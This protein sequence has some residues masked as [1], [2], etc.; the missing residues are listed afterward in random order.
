MNKFLLRI[1]VPLLLLVGLASPTY[2]QSGGPQASGDPPEPQVVMPVLNYHLSMPVVSSP[3]PSGLIGP[4]GGSVVVIVPDPSDAAVIYAGSWGAGVYKS[5]DGGFNW[6]PARKG[7]TN[8]LINSMAVDPQNSQVVYAGTYKD[9][10]FKSLD[11]GQSW[12]QSSN[13]LQKAAVVYSM[14]IDP[15]NSNRLYAGTRGENTTGQPPWRG[16]LYKSEDGGAS[17]KPI[18]ENIGGSGAQDW[19][20]SLAVLPRDPNMILAASHEHGPYLTLDYG[21]TWAPSSSGITDGSGRAVLFDPR[22]RNPATSYFGVWHRSGI[23]KSTDNAV[24][25][26]AKT[27]GIGNT[28]I[29]SM[30]IDNLDPSQLYATTFIASSGDTGGVLRS[31]DSGNSWKQAGL[32]GYSIYTVAVNIAN[33]DTLYAGVFNTGLFRS[34]NRG[35]SWGPSENGMSNVGVSSVLVRPNSPNNIFTATSTVLQTTNRGENW[36][37]V[38]GGL[39]S[40]TVNGMAMNPTNPDILFALT[41]SSGLYRIDLSSG[42]GWSKQTA[43]SSS[44]TLQSDPRPLQPL[45]ELHM[46]MPDE[47]FE[48]QPQAVPN[49]PLLA[50]VFAPSNAE[51]RLPGQLGQRGVP[52][53]RRRLHLE[54]GRA[55]RAG[56]DQP[57]G[58]SNQPGRGLRHNRRL[59][60]GQVEHQRRAELERHGPAGR[61]N[62]LRAVDLRRRPGHGLPGRQQRPVPTRLERRLDVERAGG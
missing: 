55:G 2:G 29:Y 28:K 24:S 36:S 61:D 9:G 22:Y 5:T 26:T 45:D 4:F 1:L 46:L 50:M 38:A 42:S 32:S 12:T 18:L 37:A 6:Q 17:W 21:K 41:Q 15:E 27:S 11:G 57:G 62:P 48:A 40:G 53:R 34:D 59:R 14:A 43:L 19:I 3:D 13:G 35:G 16:I 58:G 30:A 49:A 47:P 20:Y 7:L 23:F 51:H 31:S 44:P 10:V 39:P 25:W 60:D 56:G 8:L 54:C 33:S 52:Q